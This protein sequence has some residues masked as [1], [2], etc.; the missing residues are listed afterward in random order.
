[1][2]ASLTVRPAGY[3]LRRR[4]EPIDDAAEEPD[5]AKQRLRIFRCDILRRASCQLAQHTKVFDAFAFVWSERVTH[6][7]RFLRMTFAWACKT[8]VAARKSL[9]SA[10]L[11]HDA[12]RS[13][14]K[15]A[16]VSNSNVTNTRRRFIVS[17]PLAYSPTLRSTPAP[18][19]AGTASA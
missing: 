12:E 7:R 15:P 8:F 4:R 18:P 11:H 6:G 14:T 3:A 1:M 19:S 10:R 2:A 9:R 13:A 16:S 17:P 5:S